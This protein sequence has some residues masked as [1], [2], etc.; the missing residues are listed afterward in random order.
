MAKSSS[1]EIL[2]IIKGIVIGMVGAYVIIEI[3]K[4]LW[5]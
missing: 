2:D 1:D 4:A 5:F 3:V